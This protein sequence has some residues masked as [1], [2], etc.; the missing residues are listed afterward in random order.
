MWSE[1]LVNAFTHEGVDPL[2][3]DILDRPRRSWWQQVARPGLPWWALEKLPQGGAAAFVGLTTRRSDYQVRAVGTPASSTY[4][5][6][7]CCWRDR[8]TERT[9]SRVSPPSSALVPVRRRPPTPSGT[10]S[11]WIDDYFDEPDALGVARRRIREAVAALRKAGVAH[12]DLQH[13]N[14]L[15]GSDHQVRFVDY[16]GMFLPALRE[17]GA[18]ER[19]HRNYQHP[20]RADHYDESIDLFATFVIDLSLEAL[21]YEP[22]LWDKFHTGENPLF[23]AADLVRPEESEVFAGLAEIGP[24]ADRLQRLR[25]ACTVDFAAVP[26]TL[27]GT[28]NARGNGRTPCSHYHLPRPVPAAERETLLACQGDEVTTFGQVTDTRVWQTAYGKMAFINLGDWRRGDFAIIAFDRTCV[29]LC[30][31]YD[32]DLT[33]LRGRWVSITGLVTAYRGKR[34]YWTPQIELSRLR[35]LRMLNAQQVKEFE[36]A[37]D[38]DLPDEP[39]QVCEPP[40]AQRSW[41]DVS[42]PPQTRSAPAS[43]S[44]VPLHGRPAV[45]ASG[46]ADLQ[47]RLGKLYSSPGFAAQGLSAWRERF[48]R[49][50]NS[51][52]GWR[53]LQPATRAASANA[54]F[55]GSPPVGARTS[56][57]A[58][59]GL[60]ATA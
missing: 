13:G 53:A 27:R 2:A 3:P 59:S 38:G 32:A 4:V 31:E 6:R 51:V 25:V 58:A 12:G 37:A 43:T 30:Q 48:N 1:I 50:G 40:K 47:Q 39:E 52:A 49:I 54:I 42:E 56:S 36:E 7:R 14:I 19:G 23:S 15:V 29:E 45:S 33:G 46:A 24:L 34:P 10:E 11:D 8:S 41:R 55:N 35:A 18:S 5:G 16:D 28:G 17:L 44:A 26:E 21:Q 60:P 9:C 20:D 22:G 57:A